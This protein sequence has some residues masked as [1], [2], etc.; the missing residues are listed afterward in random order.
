M[1]PWTSVRE[2]FWEN[3]D[4]PT[5]EFTVLKLAIHLSKVQQS[6]FSFTTFWYPAVPAGCEK[7]GNFQRCSSDEQL[8]HFCDIC[9]S[10]TGILSFHAITG[11]RHVPFL[12][13]WYSLVSGLWWGYPVVQ[14][15]PCY[16]SQGDPRTIIPHHLLWL[17]YFDIAVFETDRASSRNFLA[18]G[19]FRIYCDHKWPYPATPSWYPTPSSTPAPTYPGL[20]SSWSTPTASPNPLHGV[21]PTPVQY[22]PHPPAYR[23]P[24]PTRSITIGILLHLTPLFHHKLHL[25]RAFPTS[26][27]RTNLDNHTTTTRKPFQSSSPGASPSITSDSDS[28]PAI[29]NDPLRR[30]LRNRHL[31]LWKLILPDAQHPWLPPLAFNISS[32]HT[33]TKDW[34]PSSP[35]RR[36]K[37]H[38]NLASVHLWTRHPINLHRSPPLLPR[39]RR[40]HSTP[41]THRSRSSCR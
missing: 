19:F 41:K 24:Q 11:S 28:L 29:N 38:S 39:S 20:T 27:N 14:D 23:E 22:Y 13:V 34:A 9:T 17:E 40:C 36:G 26:I 3:V 2:P 5:S 32:N 37:L 8:K 4:D 6:A 35:L 25:H 7:H 15:W 18:L 10:S 1:V 12:Q 33:W 31:L 16:P 30:L 21:P